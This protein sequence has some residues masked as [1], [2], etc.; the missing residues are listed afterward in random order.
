MN[1]QKMVFVINS[2]KSNY[3]NSPEFASIS[4]YIKPTM[5]H[6]DGDIETFCTEISYSTFKLLDNQFSFDFD[7]SAKQEGKVSYKEFL[8]ENEIQSLSYFDYGGEKI[9]RLLLHDMDW[10]KVKSKDLK[11]ICDKLQNYLASHQILHSTEVITEDLDKLSAIAEF[12]SSN[13]LNLSVFDPNF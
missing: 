1:E 3:E 6:A 7:R 13:N 12:C 10:Y 8:N 2:S 5:W 4:S 11:L 9:Y